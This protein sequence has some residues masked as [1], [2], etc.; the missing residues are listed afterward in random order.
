MRRGQINNSDHSISVDNP[1]LAPDSIVFPFVYGN[2]IVGMYQ[3]VVDYLGFIQCIP[4]QGFLLYPF[5]A[6]TVYSQIRQCLP[7]TL[8]LHFQ[9]NV[10]L[11][12]FIVD[13]F[14]MKIASHLIGHLINRSHQTIGGG[15]ESTRLIIVEPEQQSKTD[16]FQQNEKKPIIVFQKEIQQIPHT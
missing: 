12:Q 4:L 16:T 11:H 13:R 5:D 6:D 9:M 14:Q 10:P 15:K 1:H 8:Y 7:K 3:T 2:V